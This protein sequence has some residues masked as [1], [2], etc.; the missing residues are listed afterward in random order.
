MSSVPGDFEQELRD[1]LSERTGYECAKQFEVGKSGNRWKVDCVLLDEHGVRKGY[2][3]V[4]E[5]SRSANRSTYINH[6]RR[7]YAEMGDF[8]QLDAPKAVVVAEKW[9]FGRI[10]WDAM[11]RSIDCSL[12]DLD[13]LDQL[14]SRVKE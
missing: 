4:K 9:D 1:T 8:R 2:V 11:F 5:T 6:M 3:E 14:V 13:E 12:V 7:A 10:D